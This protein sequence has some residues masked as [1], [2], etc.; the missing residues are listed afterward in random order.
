[1]AEGSLIQILEIGSKLH[2]KERTYEIIRVLGS[3]SFG[4]TYLAKAKVSVGNISTSMS[5]AIK[6]HF[7]SASCYRDKDGATVLTVP[8]AKSDVVDSRADFITEANRLKK[9]CLKSRNI[10]SVNETFEANG[11]AYYVMEYLDGG[12]PSRCSEKD[13]VS[14]VMQIAE[15]L[16]EIHKEHVL[17]L[18][19][20]PDNIVLKTNERNETYPVLIDFGISKHFDSKGHPTSSLSAK[21]A[22][23]GYAPQE[24]YAGVNEFSPKY[25][26]Y[27]LA[28]VL[29]YLCTGKNPPDAFKI[30]PNQQELK[31]EL[32]GKV[33]PRVE[34]A[35]LNAMKPSA[36][37]RTSS[38][39]QFCDDL[40]GND[41]VPMLRVSSSN[42]DFGMGKGQQRVLV[43]SNIGWTAYSD[44]N[45]CKVSKSGNTILISVAQNKESGNRS[46]SVIV[47]G[48]SYQV[49]KILRIMQDGSGTIVLPSGH[50]WW[51]RYNRN[52]CKAGGIIL[53]A[54]IIAGVY[55]LFKIDP[56]KESL[57][58]TEAI[59]N[60]NVKL[61]KEFA[62]RDSIRAYLPYA[63]I[64]ADNKQFKEAI[65]YAQKTRN[66]IY[67]VSAA[68]LIDSINHILK[69]ST[70]Q[71]DVL[72]NTTSIKII[73]S[74]FVLIE[75]DSYNYNGWNEKSQTEYSRVVP[76]DSF[77]IS[78]Y[79]LTQSEYERI[80]GDLKNENV[81][82]GVGEY[83]GEPYK[84]IRGDSI[85]VIASLKEIAEYCNK[86]SE[87]E[88][89]K[90]FYN[91]DGSYITINK[92]GNGYRI[93]TEVEWLFAAHSGNMHEKFKYSGSN[94]LGEVAWYGG[95]SGIR[96][97][98]VGRKKPNGK[99]LYDM[100]GNVDE[101]LWSSTFDG[102]WYP[103]S[104][105]NYYMWVGTI[106]DIVGS[107]ENLGARI[108]LVPQNN[109]NLKMDSPEIPK[110]MKNIK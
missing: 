4:I 22:S 65:D 1:M 63:Q 73:P 28:A 13:A 9:L 70:I 50:T 11:T 79:E 27:A 36:A 93:P 58:L 90:G 8:T 30:S 64:L 104:Y 51:Q 6:E 49:S 19:L 71:A 89:Y 106:D 46:C 29:F 40:M 43:D 72:S 25:D 94:K 52:V 96:P 56:E 103:H 35:I 81:T 57:R 5:F 95:N 66:S 54:C 92:D 88:G 74:D 78:R 34:K 99:G 87:L 105:M 37:E 86:R 107:Q 100:T 83:G 76:V 61:L 23:P 80:M 109:D 55:S 38:I 42:L 75:A 47:D 31:K 98:S 39:Q 102:T 97:H 21:G 18:D 68:T 16:D 67:Y 33:S 44:S 110:K 2:S 60:N 84:Q 82:F 53:V 108:V 69:N 10:V 41:F 15:A 32:A 7:I 14:I 20:K 85:P 101:Y 45:W 91:F 48:S 59:E 17:H 12:C 77:Y 24:Q 62:E 3:G 26:I